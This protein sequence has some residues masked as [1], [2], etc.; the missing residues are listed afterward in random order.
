MAAFEREER[1]MFKTMMA[2]APMMIFGL[3]ERMRA[4]APVRL[5]VRVV[6]MVLGAAGV[7]TGRRCLLGAIGLT[8]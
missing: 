4:T 5:M 1:Q 6:W 7:G 2:T 8:G 3:S